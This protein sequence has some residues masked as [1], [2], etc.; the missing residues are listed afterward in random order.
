[1]RI[2]EELAEAVKKPLG[3]IT[4]ADK[5]G[6]PVV[7]GRTKWVNAFHGTAGSITH[8]L[9]PH[10]GFVWATL[11]PEHASSYAVSDRAYW[12]GGDNPAVLLFRINIAGFLIITGNGREIREVDG[13]DWRTGMTPYDI[14][15]ELSLPGILFK[16]VYDTVDDERF[17]RAVNLVAVADTSR[18]QPLFNQPSVSG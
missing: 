10:G 11:S 6:Y 1:M 18:I 3:K 9:I 4:S 16:K 14:V 2:V 13:E 17:N 8:E 12:K 7:G 15:H 5:E